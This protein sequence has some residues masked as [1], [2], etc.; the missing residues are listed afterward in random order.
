MFKKPDS[1]YKERINRFIGIVKDGGLYQHWCDLAPKE[2]LDSKIIADY[3]EV[4]EASI[5]VLQLDF[6]L[7]P[8]CIWSAGLILSF[9]VFLFE[10]VA[11]S[12][13]KLLKYFV[14]KYILLT[15]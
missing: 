8:F 15:L 12:F 13:A 14:L 10:F 4:E 7:Y 6:F 11:P 2:F 5:Q 1:E 3:P 9:L